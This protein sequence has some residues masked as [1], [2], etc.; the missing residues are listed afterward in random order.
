[1][2]NATNISGKLIKP[3]HTTIGFDSTIRLNQALVPAN[4]RK[5]VPRMGR[6][7]PG[8]R[9]LTS[10]LKSAKKPYNNSVIPNVDKQCESVANG[11]SGWNP[12]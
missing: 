8:T 6:V 4:R 3:N 10:R 9:K 11:R 12:F 1:M 7:W 5:V 2:A